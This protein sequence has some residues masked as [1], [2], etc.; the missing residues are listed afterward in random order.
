MTS[1]AWSIAFYNHSWDWR[2]I[3][4]Q[5]HSKPDLLLFRTWNLLFRTWNLLFRT[6]AG[7]GDQACSWYII[8][9]VRGLEIFW[10]FWQNIRN[11]QLCFVFL[12]FSLLCQNISACLKLIIMCQNTERKIPA[13]WLGT[14]TQ[15]LTQYSK[16]SSQ[17]RNFRTQYRNVHCFPNLERLNY[18]AKIDSFCLPK[19]TQDP[20]KN[21][22]DRS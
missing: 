15:A 22:R 20:C 6:T 12:N 5:N 1:Q 11:T 13:I 17:Y 19:L 7:T 21:I 3:A 2:S 8:M 18:H 16:L 14:K 4:F 10:H 9:S